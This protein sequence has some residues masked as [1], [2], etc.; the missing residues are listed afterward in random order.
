MTATAFTTRHRPNG[1]EP[2]NSMT[3]V[4][5]ARNFVCRFAAVSRSS[6]YA[7]NSCSPPSTRSTCPEMY[8]DASEARKATTRAISSG[9][10]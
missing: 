9:Q 8:D 4:M 10:P 2:G 3:T 5:E 1:H 6:V 7:G